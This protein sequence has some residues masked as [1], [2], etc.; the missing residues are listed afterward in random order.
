MPTSSHQGSRL[1]AE[2]DHRDVPRNEMGGSPERSCALAVE[3][4]MKMY[5]ES[6]TDVMFVDLCDAAPDDLI[7]VVEVGDQVGFPGQIQVRVNREK[8]ILYG[9]TIQKFSRFKRS[10]F[11]KYRM[12]SVRYALL[13]LVIALRAG[14]RLEPPRPALQTW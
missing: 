12:A 5:L 14:L 10:L 9:I 2:T 1:D 13:L 11:W 8:Q 3:S 7:D 4:K 6:R